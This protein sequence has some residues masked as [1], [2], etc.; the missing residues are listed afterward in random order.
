M[1]VAL[2]AQDM[3]ALAVQCIFG[4]ASVAIKVT[5]QRSVLSATTRGNCQNVALQQQ[6]QWRWRGLQ[7]WQK[8]SASD[9]QR[10]KCDAI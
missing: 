10:D 3:A 6:Q 9:R 2:I 8:L 4:N 1:T 7:Q 5:A